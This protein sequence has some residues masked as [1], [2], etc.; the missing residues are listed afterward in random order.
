MSCAFHGWPEEKPCAECAESAAHLRAKLGEVSVKLLRAEQAVA[1]TQAANAVL[2]TLVESA[3]V[4]A[5]HNNNA[6]SEKAFTKALAHKPDDSALREALLEV[7]Y[8]V[9]RRCRGLKPDCD[10][11]EL[12]HE[13]VADEVRRVLGTDTIGEATL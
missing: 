10:P 2:R 4:L 11:E 7:G 1:A 5:M 8:G 3:R 12:N 6:A 13:F 9:Y